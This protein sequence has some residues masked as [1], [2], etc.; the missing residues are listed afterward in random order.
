MGKSKRKQTGGWVIT[1]TVQSEGRCK[2]LKS[3][4]HQLYRA[5]LQP[6]SFRWQ[7]TIPVNPPSVP[8]CSDLCVWGA[9]Q[10][11]LEHLCVSQVLHDDWLVGIVSFDNIQAIHLELFTHLESEQITFLTCHRLAGVWWEDSCMRSFQAMATDALAFRVQKAGQTLSR[12]LLGLP[13]N[14]LSFQCI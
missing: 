14:P 8:Q 13:E 9:W 7:R 1:E 6:D 4:H 12:L 11:Q 10:A 3:T 5:L 2:I